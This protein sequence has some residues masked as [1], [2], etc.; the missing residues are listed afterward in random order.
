MERITNIDYE[1]IKY[2]K[3]LGNNRLELNIKGKNINYIIIN[4]IRR[5]IL[6]NIP[7]YTFNEFNFTINES[8][9]NNNYIK[10]RLRN[11]PVW[12]IANTIDKFIDNKNINNN[13][14]NN[15]LGDT[16]NNNSGDDI[17][18]NIDDELDLENKN[19][20]DINTSSLKQLTMYINY[21]N[22]DKSI[23]TVTTDNAKF[24]Y[25][26][27]NIKSPYPIPIPI[28]KLQK[29]QAINFSSITV[30]GTEKEDSIFSAV[31][32]CY[33]N[34]INE[35]EF[36][37]MLESRGQLSE[38]RII[39]VALINIINS[40]EN[41]AKIVT[42][43]QVT[44]IGEIIINGENNTMGNLLSYGMQNHKNVKFAGYNIPHLLENKVIIHYELINENIKLKD[45]F[46]DVS[47]YFIELFNNL[48]KNNLN[49]DKKAQDVEKKTKTK[50]HD[51]EKKTTEIK[52]KTPDVEKKIKE[53]NK[54]TSV[55]KKV[56]KNI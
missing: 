18:L 10:L 47:I 12:G 53:I 17:N 51:G 5:T 41:L 35:N 27:K 54:K 6:T 49:I 23:M 14:D 32:V 55:E 26:D 20:I 8:I 39:E 24:Y 37:F 52:K 25:S 42:Y 7:I 30:L 33:Y 11:L 56:S 13:L 28:I 50:T 38:Q 34:E 9:F 3:D 22:T 36:I 48:I 19:N 43:E 46:D 31:S 45:V 15:N 29:N 21:K 1:V 40:I 2:N 16:R 4:T 44:H